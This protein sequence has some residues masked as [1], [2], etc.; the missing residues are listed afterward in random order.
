[1]RTGEV[2]AELTGGPCP[3]DE[4]TRVNGRCT[5]CGRDHRER[6][7]RVPGHRQR[8]YRVIAGERIFSSHVTIGKAMKAVVRAEKLAAEGLCAMTPTTLVY[9]ERWSSIRNTWESMS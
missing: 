8:R 4:S 6:D 7:Q 3:C 9:I 1:M 2:A 5:S